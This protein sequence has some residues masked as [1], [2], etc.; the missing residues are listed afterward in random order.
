MRQS[1][2]ARAGSLDHC[3]SFAGYAHDS[4]AGIMRMGHAQ[5]PAE[6]ER[7]IT[8]ALNFLLRGF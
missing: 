1:G 7:P 3:A 6:Q 8:A 2:A 5:G 4:C